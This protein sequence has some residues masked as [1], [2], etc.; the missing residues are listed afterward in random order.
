MADVHHQLINAVVMAAGSKERC[1]IFSDFIL[2][3]QSNGS[4]AEQLQGCRF[5]PG[6]LRPFVD[7][8]GQHCVIVN[9]GRM[10][11]DN[12]TGRM[13]PVHEKH[14]IQSL[15]A[16]NIES[17]VFNAT[18]LRKDEWV[19]LDQVVITA[20]RQRLR[21]WADLAAANTFGGFNAMAKLT[22][23]YE[24]ASDPGEAVVDMEGLAPGRTDSP[25][26]KLRS[27]PL[28]ITHSDFWFSARRLAVSRNTGTPL[29]TTMAE[30]AGRRVAETIEK[31]LIGVETG[32]SYGSR[33]TGQN[34]HDG[35][36]TVYGYTTLPSRITVTNLTIPTGSNPEATV[37]DILRLRNLMYGY[38]F[39]GPFMVYHSTDWDLFLDNDY[40]RL[41]GSNASMTL[42][43]R[44]RAI[45][46]IQ[47]VRRLDFLTSTYTLI[48]VQM[49]PDVAR[50]IDGM[51]ITVVQWEDA[52]G[53]RLNFKVMA[54]QVPQLRYDY[55]G[56][57][58]I[59]HAT[60]A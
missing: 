4:V 14:T 45:E 5:D 32:I 41:G 25:L 15:R 39:Y 31:T 54:I 11:L 43:D 59:I 33:S 35:N 60:T 44:I 3:G 2:N 6:L 13:V 29:D 53:M 58:G 42:R 46:G 26:Y 51:G 21:A 22:L 10:V 47:D 56:I 30:A 9:T 23:E 24:A 16:R 48:I 52:G 57:A 34:A 49:T 38:K 20:A 55:N 40:A 8:R 17:P 19:Q 36:S 37:G 28:P 1:T 50:A 12:K 7:A 18:S 27:L